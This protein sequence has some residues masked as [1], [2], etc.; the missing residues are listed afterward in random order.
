MG[1]AAMVS[2]ALLDLLVSLVVEVRPKAKMCGVAARRIITSVHNEQPVWDSAVYGF[3]GN[4]VG[5]PLSAVVVSDDAVSVAVYGLQPCP[6]T[7]WRTLVP[8]LSE[9]LVQWPLPVRVVALKRAVLSTGACLTK[10]APDTQR[11]RHGGIIARVRVLN[12]NA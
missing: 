8:C 3:V 12:H 1:L 2:T 6:A 10:I 11:F 7:I 4:P 5:S 9:S